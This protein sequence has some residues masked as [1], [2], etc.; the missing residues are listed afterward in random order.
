ML[1]LPLSC[2]DT[3]CPI[4]LQVQ[5]LYLPSLPVVHL[6]LLQSLHLQTLVIV[7]MGGGPNLL[8]PFVIWG[9]AEQ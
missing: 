8:A 3:L 4:S 2:T 1:V 9:H 6:Y 7:L 5:H